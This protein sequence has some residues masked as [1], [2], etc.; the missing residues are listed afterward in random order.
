MYLDT[1]T[2]ITVYVWATVPTSLAEV[3]DMQ[4]CLSLYKKAGTVVL[5]KEMLDFSHL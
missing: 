1:A 5:L 2:S 3:F 4:H